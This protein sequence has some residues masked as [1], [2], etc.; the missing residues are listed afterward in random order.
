ML[1]RAFA[2]DS[3]QKGLPLPFLLLA[4]SLGGAFLPHVC[5][6]SFWWRRGCDWNTGVSISQST[7]LT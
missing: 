4:L 2:K 6:P 7:D 5:V 3:T 1:L